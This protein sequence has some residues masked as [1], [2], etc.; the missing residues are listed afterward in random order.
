[1]RQITAIAKCISRMLFKARKRVSKR[2][3]SAALRTLFFLLSS[4]FPFPKEGSEV[5]SQPIVMKVFIFC[6]RTPWRNFDSGPNELVIINY[7]LPL[8][9]HTAA[10]AATAARYLRHVAAC[11]GRQ[12]EWRARFRVRTARSSQFATWTRNGSLNI[13][14]FD[15]FSFL[16]FCYQI[17]KVLKLLHFATNR[18]QTLGLHTDWWKLSTTAPWRPDFQ[19]K[20]WLINNK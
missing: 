9:L 4:D 17:F 13:V 5:V 7:K 6:I 1:M 20:S 11:S 19:V 18:N 15:F 8:Y 3:P 12:L 10:A 14:L 2:A 16:F